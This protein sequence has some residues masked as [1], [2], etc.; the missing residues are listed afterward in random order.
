M[1][2]SECQMIGNLGPGQYRLSKTRQMP[3]SR[4]LPPTCISETQLGRRTGAWMDSACTNA[5]HPVSRVSVGSKALLKHDMGQIK[6]HNV[7]NPSQKSKTTPI[8]GISSK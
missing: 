4:W 3:S 6:T 8:I 5:A 7:E 1:A 2:Q